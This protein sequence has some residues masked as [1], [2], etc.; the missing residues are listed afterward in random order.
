M[1]ALEPTLPVSS[2][3]KNTGQSG[4][5]EHARLYPMLR[6]PSFTFTGWP[7]HKETTTGGPHFLA[8]K[9]RGAA[10]GQMTVHKRDGT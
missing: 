7:L 3:I 6:T 2:V 5:R 10:L 8:Y 9:R 1:M 4:D